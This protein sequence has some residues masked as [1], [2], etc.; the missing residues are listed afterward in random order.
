[1]SWLSQSYSAAVNS[2]GIWCLQLRR[3]LRHAAVLRSALGEESGG[4][5]VHTMGGGVRKR[6]R[7]SSD[8][9]EGGRAHNRNSPTIHEKEPNCNAKDGIWRGGF[10]CQAMHLQAS[11][12]VLH[13]GFGTFQN[14]IDGTPSVSFRFV[15]QQI[16]LVR[17]GIVST[18]N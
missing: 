8:G 18:I 11:S 16:S 6:G 4:I 7:R 17:S 13:F 14:M 9:R 12:H 3:I 2:V 5:F 15:V 1:M 10:R